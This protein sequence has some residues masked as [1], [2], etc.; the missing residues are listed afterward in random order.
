MYTNNMLG[1]WI[2]KASH[3]IFILTVKSKI[4]NCQVLEAQVSFFDTKNFTKGSFQDL[5]L[6]E[7][8]N[9]QYK[10]NNLLTKAVRGTSYNWDMDEENAKKQDVQNL[11]FNWSNKWNSP[12]L[13]RI[14]FGSFEKLQNTMTSFPKT[15]TI[16]ENPHRQ[17][18][19]M[20][21]APDSMDLKV[22]LNEN[23]IVFKIGK[24]TAIAEFKYSGFSKNDFAVFQMNS[25][26]KEIF[27]ALTFKKFN[28][29]WFNS[30]VR[31]KVYNSKVELYQNY[32]FDK[33]I[34]TL[35]FNQAN[36]NPEKYNKDGS[37]I[38]DNW[39]SKSQS[40]YSYDLTHSVKIPTTN[41]TSSVKFPLGMKLRG[42]GYNGKR[43]CRISLDY[44][45]NA[46]VE[47]M[48]KDCNPNKFSAKQGFR[49]DGMINFDHVAYAKMKNTWGKK[50]H[51]H[52]KPV[53]WGYDNDFPYSITL[54][55]N[56]NT[57]TFNNINQ[58]KI[59][60]HF[61]LPKNDNEYQIIEFLDPTAT[62]F[63]I[64]NLKFKIV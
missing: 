26:V 24:K 30:Q 40:S 60:Q 3:G 41:M 64:L 47:K 8:G 5:T 35:T 25:Q 2:T 39:T 13:N 61:K 53:I 44:A 51:D 9:A 62:E 28:I 49:S 22:T 54:E 63:T 33:H 1:K 59:H 43:D 15:Y 50:V 46:K 45:G 48:N 17:R 14:N 38:L 16:V 29:N 6:D 32:G 55:V 52:S 23:S 31:K 57:P 18:G 10:L 56:P 58:I 19:E 20:S 42:K 4:G 21:F 27:K 12:N 7:N 37:I 36:W 34:Q 11:K